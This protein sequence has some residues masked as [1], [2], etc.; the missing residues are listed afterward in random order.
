MVRVLS[1]FLCG[2]LLAGVHTSAKA[3][4]IEERL[5]AQR[6]MTIDTNL[7]EDWP[8]GP[9]VS[10]ESAIL[11]D[12]NSGTILYGKNIHMQ[13]YPASTTK[14]LTTLLATELCSPEEIVT[15]SYNAVHD[16]PPGSSGIAMDV[17]QELTVEQC[18]NAILIRSANECCFALAEHITGTTDWSVFAEIMNARAKELGAINSNFVNP[19]GLPDDNH[20][21]TAYDL[22]MIGRGFFAND[23][24][25]NISLT[26][27]L[28]I[29]ASE[30]LP[31][32]KLEISSMQIIPGG[33]YEYEYLVGCK[34]GYTVAARSC[35]VS[36]A[37]KDGLKLICV[38]MKDESPLQYE[39]T[40]ALFNYGFS[41]FAKVN[42]ATEETRY[43]IDS[44]GL[45][46]AGNDLFGS[47]KS[48][49]SLNK[50]DTILL[51][52]NA[53]LADTDSTI[54]YS[55][56]TAEEAAVITYTYHGQQVG[57]VRVELDSLAEEMAGFET[58]EESEVAEEESEGK[59][60]FINLLKIA[61]YILGGIAVFFVIFLLVRFFLYRSRNRVEKNNRRSWKRRR[62][63]RRRGSGRSSGF[64]DIDF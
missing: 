18:L 35:L 8:E 6:A 52:R 37:E 63:R 51:P 53:S 9:V 55:D 16:N 58:P 30:K 7:I 45:F 32:G 15:F 23:H 34:T 64:R 28:E 13:E 61:A 48:I 22:A 21:T 27:R 25:C 10:A 29:P 59:V 14:I 40:I 39:D 62:K 24:L 1:L 43:Q 33:K 11:M 31:E 60:I 41:N 4:A 36:C 56:S 17:G 2:S 57:T 42:V 46:Y 49:L 54:I 19:N 5:Q 3:D 12:M 47:S 26:R 44:T 38:V 20:Y 50:E